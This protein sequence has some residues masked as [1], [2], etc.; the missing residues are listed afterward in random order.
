MLELILDR[1]R[2][3]VC[4]SDIPPAIPPA[5]IGDGIVLF[6]RMSLLMC[7]VATNHTVTREQ[8][9]LF[10]KQ[11]QQTPEV[12]I[13]ETCSQSGAFPEKDL[14]TILR[15]SILTRFGLIYD[16]AETAEKL[17]IDPDGN[18]IPYERRVPKRA[19]LSP[20]DWIAGEGPQRPVIKE[21][22]QLYGRWLAEVDNTAKKQ[23]VISNGGIAQHRSLQII[24][25]LTDWS[26]YGDPLVLA[27]RNSNTAVAKPAG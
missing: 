7:W 26:K 3:T 17:P 14:Q 10:A 18:V 4:A 12:S 24:V 19:P 13:A 25:D 16:Q 22:H 9:D 15:D 2:K 27:G 21:L 6:D 20:V 1:L 11:L 5:L 23:F 8:V